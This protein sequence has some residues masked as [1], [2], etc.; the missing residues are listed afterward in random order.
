MAEELPLPKA[1]PRPPRAADGDT[2]PGIASTDYVK[3]KQRTTAIR[4]GSIIALITAA[5]TAWS[6]YRST[7]NAKEEATKTDQADFERLVKLEQKLSDHIDA[8]NK[9]TDKLEKKVDHG[10]NVQAAMNAKLDMELDH[11]GVPKDRRPQP[12]D[13]EPAGPTGESK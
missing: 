2:Q 1:G 10:A 4:M 3:R 12:E 7:T 6:E 11:H 9:R 5:L 8:E 13:F